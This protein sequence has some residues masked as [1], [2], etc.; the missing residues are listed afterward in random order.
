MKMDKVERAWRTKVA[1]IR[2]GVSGSTSQD[3]TKE[4]NA[5]CSKDSQ[6][7]GTRLYFHG[8]LGNLSGRLRNIPK[9][10]DPLP[11]MEA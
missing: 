4:M 2:E 5:P 1:A 10:D 3:W 11:V 8:A 9:T 7:N 6:F